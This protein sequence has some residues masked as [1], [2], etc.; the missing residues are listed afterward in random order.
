LLEGLE[1][2]TETDFYANNMRNIN[3]LLQQAFEQFPKI[4]RDDKGLVKHVQA[5][6][7]PRKFG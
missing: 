4:E 2:E 5:T 7:C 3:P 1:R 6:K